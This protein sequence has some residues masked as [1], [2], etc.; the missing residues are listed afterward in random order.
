MPSGSARLAPAVAAALE[1]GRIL[2]VR[3]G[4]AHRFIG[5]WPVVV[6]GRLFI[7]SWSRSRDGWH[8]AIR[9]QRLATIQVG[10]RKLRVR[11]IQRRGERLLAAVDAAYRA[12][13]H[14]PRARAYVRD[15]CR[16]ACRATTTELVPIARAT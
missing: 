8:A 14:T 5:V 9:A 16:P 1:T 13:Y 10:A 3:V 15:F 12:K 11:A 6:D 4:A 7:R 2:G